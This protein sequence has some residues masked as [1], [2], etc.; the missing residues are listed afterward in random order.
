MSLFSCRGCE[1]KEAEIRRLLE[2]QKWFE[3]QVDRQNK[4]LIELT[5][6]GANTRVVQ[7]D[8][9]DRKPVTAPTRAAP[10][11]P[12]LPGTEPAPPP[13]WEVDAES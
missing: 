2:R 6:P 7:A 8:R 13:A 1:A 3:D 12:L 10:A 11:P 4:R 9:L 5:D